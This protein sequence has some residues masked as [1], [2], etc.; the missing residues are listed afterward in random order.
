[1]GDI[2]QL[3]IRGLV[4]GSIYGFVGIGF[5]AVYN[6]TGVMS[7]AVVTEGVAQELLQSENIAKSFLER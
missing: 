3:L 4:V 2:L 6:V 7:E 5:T 1:M